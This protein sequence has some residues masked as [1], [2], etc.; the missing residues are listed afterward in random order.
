MDA[1]NHCCTPESSINVMC[2][3]YLKNWKKNFKS[4]LLVSKKERKKQAIL[5]SCITVSVYL[6]YKYRNM[7]MIASW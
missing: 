6:S 4:H 2:Q 3:L 5:Y 1:P 7:A